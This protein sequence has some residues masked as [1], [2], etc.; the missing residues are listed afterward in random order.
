[1]ADEFELDDEL[2]TFVEER[3]GQPFSDETPTEPES[4]EPEEEPVPVSTLD[5]EPETPQEPTQ[6]ESESPSDLLDVAP[7]VQLPKD[8]ALSYAQF[9]ALLRNDPELFRL[10]NETV[11]GRGAGGVSTQPTLPPAPTL[12]TLPQL[13]D[14]D[15]TDPALKS[16]YD[17]ARSQQA[18][19]N[20]LQSRL[21]QVSDV[22]LTREHEEFQSLLNTTR[23]SFSKQHDLTKQ[24]MDQVQA[25]AE[26][27]NVVPSLMR[28]IDPITGTTTPRDRSTALT[29]A[30]DIAFNYIPEFREKAL[31]E[32]VQA[33]AKSSRRKQKLAGVS[34]AG[35]GMPRTEPVPTNER[36]RRDAMIR[37]VA[38]AMGEHR[39]E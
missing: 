33:R 35:G 9:D 27:L 32:A 4:P 21:Q 7:G 26:R 22:T 16:L 3:L 1:M 25:T 24:Q 29:R 31:A 28:G 12:P 39:P 13:A 23:A 17:T 8:V 14:D 36:E 11:Q 38:E 15:L 30:F 34:G 18:L 20:D 5:D 6:P 19:I 10:I 37:E 2:K